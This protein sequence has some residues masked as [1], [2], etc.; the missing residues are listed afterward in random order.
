VVAEPEEWHPGSFTK[1]FSWGP[2]SQGLK[3]LHTVIRAGFDDQLTDVPRAEFRRRVK[4]IKRPDYIPL[5]FFLYN[6][7]KHGVDYV[8][9]DELVFQALSF[10]HSAHFDRLAVFA[11]NLSR[12]GRWRGSLPYQ[13]RPALWAFHYVAD[14]VG[15]IFGWDSAKIT[16]NDIEKFVGSDSRYTGKTTRKLSTN[17]NYLYRVGRLSEYKSGRPERW[18]LSSLFLALD[19]MVRPEQ[20]IV[21][22]DIGALV[23]DQLMRSGFWHISGRRSMAKDVASI[24]FQTLYAACGGRA[25]FSSE[26]VLERQNELLPQMRPNNPDIPEGAIGVF[27]V[28][29]PAARSAIPRVCEI[30]ARYIA[31]FETFDAENLDDFDVESFV[32]ERTQQALQELRTAGIRPSIGSDALTRLM[33]GE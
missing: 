24:Y 28:T 20:L 2:E 31:G 14:R 26:A 17:L 21:G 13:Q 5:N 10:R 1:N 19:R 6:E 27:H 7:S 4:A 8:V 3:E 23:S 16:A 9:V 22:A 11:F 29:N 32:R 25:R 30:L 18:W 12:V 33:R 15:P